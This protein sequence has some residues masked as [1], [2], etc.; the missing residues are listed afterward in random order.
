MAWHPIHESM[1]ASGG[2]DGTILFWNVGASGHEEPQAKIQYAHD[3]AVWDMAWHPAGHCLVSGANDKYT[4]FWQRPITGGLMGEDYFNEIPGF[5]DRGEEDEI[6]FDSIPLGAHVGIVI[7]KKGATII[8][9]QVSA[10]G[11]EGGT[12]GGREEGGREGGA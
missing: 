8:S 5:G 9:M 2:M 6:V 12:E 4:K 3:Q 1:F 7:G 10:R 11:R